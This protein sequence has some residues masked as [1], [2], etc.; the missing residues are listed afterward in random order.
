MWPYYYREFQMAFYSP[1]VS[2]VGPDSRSNTLSLKFQFPP[3]HVDFPRLCKQVHY[4]SR[5]HRSPDPKRSISR[6]FPTTGKTLFLGV[7]K[8]GVHDFDASLQ[9][10]S[11]AQVVIYHFFSFPPAGLRR[12]RKLE[13][14]FLN[15][16]RPPSS[17]S[18]RS[19]FPFFFRASF[20]EEPSRTTFLSYSIWGY[21]DMWEEPIVKTFFNWGFYCYWI[22][23]L[24][25]FHSLA[26]ISTRFSNATWEVPKN[27]NEVLG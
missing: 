9:L 6:K 15:Q 24:G 20:P 2:N 7:K 17:T 22:F 26:S 12:S 27:A 25:N 21:H 11:K 13:A 16:M 3:L 19:P 5:G 4:W 23:F 1:A 10:T 18:K 8:N 14:V